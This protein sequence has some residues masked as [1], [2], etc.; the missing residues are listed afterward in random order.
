M[1][2]FCVGLFV[3]TLCTLSF[4]SCVYLGLTEDTQLTQPQVE[5]HYPSSAIGSLCTLVTT[6]PEIYRCL[7]PAGV[8]CFVAKSGISCIETHC[9]VSACQTPGSKLTE[10]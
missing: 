4:L 2:R 8:T 6:T 5:T 7:M 9:S 3:F 1:Y 10:L